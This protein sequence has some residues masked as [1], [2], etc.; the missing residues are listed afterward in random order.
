VHIPA[1]DAV[2]DLKAYVLSDSVCTDRVFPTLPTAVAAY[3]AWCRD[4]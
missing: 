4:R 2:D 1:L 3:E